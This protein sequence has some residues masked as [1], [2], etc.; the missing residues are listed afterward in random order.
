MILGNVPVSVHAIQ[1]IKN[2]MEI[3][4]LSAIH[5]TSLFSEIGG[6]W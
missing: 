6:F 2:S 5:N 4:M 3:R 1:S